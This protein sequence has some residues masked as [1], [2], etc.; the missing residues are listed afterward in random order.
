MVGTDNANTVT[1]DA[2]GVVPGRLDTMSSSISAIP[3][4]AMRGTENANTVIPDAAGVVPARADTLSGTLTTILADTNELQ[5]DNIPARLNTLSSSVTVIDTAVGTT[6]PALVTGLNDVSIADVNAQVLDVMN[7]DTHAEPGTG[8]P[9]STVSIFAK[10][11]WMY[12]SFRNKKRQTATVTELYN[13]DGSTIGSKRTTAGS[14]ST[15]TIGEWET[16]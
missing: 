5:G 3:T 1:P 6:I 9:G 7:V 4:T 16:G 8:A 10:I 13:D 11:N 15:S 12:K 2:A 14:S